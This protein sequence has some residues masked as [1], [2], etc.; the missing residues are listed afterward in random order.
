M[1]IHSGVAR[2]GGALIAS[3]VYPTILNSVVRKESS[4]RVIIAAQAAGASLS[5]AQALLAALPL[6][7][8]AIAKVQG[9]TSSIVGA[10]AQALTDSY[11]KGTQT[12]AYASIG[13]GGVAI[14]ACFFLEDIEP[15]M[16]PRIEV[17]LEN[18]V[19]AEKNKFH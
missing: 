11:V 9:A 15:K 7:A 2:F 17:F 6:G 1:H 18:D 5:T 10:A 4:T 12:V 19:Q 13:F 14:I 16:T 8:D 3:T